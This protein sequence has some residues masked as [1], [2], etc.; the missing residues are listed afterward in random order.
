MDMNMY[1]QTSPDPDA[2]DPVLSQLVAGSPHGILVTDEDGIVRLWN[3]ALER[4]SGI[5]LEIHREAEVRNGESY[6][7]V[8][9][10]HQRRA[11]QVHG[12]AVEPMRNPSAAKCK[13]CPCICATKSSTAP[14]KS[15]PPNW[16]TPSPGCKP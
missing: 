10:F 9:V 7:A 15:A 5:R 14:T 4:I 11:G 13:P 6:F 2:S 8:L 1:S 16:P 3:D 12:A